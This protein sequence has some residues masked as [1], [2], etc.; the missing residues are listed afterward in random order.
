VKAKGQ[1]LK[2]KVGCPRSAVH[3]PQSAVGQLAIVALGANLGNCKKNILRGMRRLEELS[4]GPLL[5]SSLWETTPVDCPPGSPPF[6]N[7]VVG[8][9]PQ[10]EETPESLLTK[11]QA[12][13]KEF[14][15]QP[16]KVLNEPRPLDLDLIAFG[17]ETRASK[18]LTIPHPRAHQRRFVLQPL[19]EIAP[20]LILPG[21]KKTVLELL[22]ELSLGRQQP[23]TK[24]SGIIIRRS[25]KQIGL[26]IDQAASEH[27][28]KRHGEAGAVRGQPLTG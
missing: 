18:E 8:L 7:A 11:L 25:L 3:G 27:K 10:A 24:D 17:R 22:E 6:V 21:Q 20:D 14:G 13:E 15:R 19:R 16:K 26:C 4:D 1:R 5:R 23:Q 2:P 12:L 9:V 28:R